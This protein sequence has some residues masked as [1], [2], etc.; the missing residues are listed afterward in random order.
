[1][2][3][4]CRIGFAG[5]TA[6][7]QPSDGGVAT[8]DD[9]AGGLAAAA[10]CARQPLPPLQHRLERGAGDANKS[11]VLVSGDG[12]RV[13]VLLLNGRPDDGRGDEAAAA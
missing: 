5:R 9:P 2:R 12:S 8:V 10:I 4:R 11:N 3:S 6:A 7:G 13:A 1:V